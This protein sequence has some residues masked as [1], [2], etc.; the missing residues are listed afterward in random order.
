MARSKTSVNDCPGLLDPKKC[1]NCPFPDDCHLS[2]DFSTK[3]QINRAVEEALEGAACLAERQAR[4]MVDV[5]EEEREQR[6]RL[7]RAYRK[8]CR[9]ELAEKQA[10][11]KTARLRRGLLLSEAARAI[12]VSY[13]TLSMWEHGTAPANWDKVYRVFPELKEAAK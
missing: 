10:C 6:L 13:P 11:I 7:Q 4:P 8:K 5:D 9:E 2:A 12:G 3:G 1:L